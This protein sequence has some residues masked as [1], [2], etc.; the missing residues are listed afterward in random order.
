MSVKEFGEVSG[1]EAEKIW[2]TKYGIPLG[3]MGTAQDYAQVVFAAITVSG[4]DIIAS[5]SSSPCA[6]SCVITR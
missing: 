3:K 2:R 5:P 6:G 1:E 4:M